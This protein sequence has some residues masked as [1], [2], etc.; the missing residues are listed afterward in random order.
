MSWLGGYK[1]KESKSVSE[2]IEESR[3]KKL[4][5]DREL[6][7]KKRAELQKRFE[8]SEKAK[9]E[10]EEACQ[11]LLDFDPD[12][13]QGPP[14]HNLSDDILYTTEVVKMVNFDEKNEDNGEEAMKSLG[15]I[16]VKWNPTDPAFFFQQLE[17]ELM[18][19]SVNK[20][21]TKRQAL[22]RNLPEDVSLEF[23]HLV[24]LQEDAAGD[25]A[26]KTLKTALLKAHGPRPG[27]AY[28]RAKNRVMLSKPS[29]L[30]K[31]LISDICN[32]NMAG[33][34]CAATV[35]GL[36]QDK[37]PMYLKTGL[38]NEIFSSTTSQEIMDKAD[39][40]WAANQP[41][42]PTVAAVSTTASV[43]TPVT[44]ETSSEIAAIGRGKNSF[45]GRNR[46]NRGFRGNGRGRS[47]PSG[48]DPRGKRHESNPPWN[49]CSAHWV[50][51]DKA[52]KCGAPTTC[53]MVN[54]V[55]PKS[56]N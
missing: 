26:Y 8:A 22:I 37:I 11:Q 41:N 40:L 14:D 27:D 56:Q 42:E 15:Q 34:C 51:Y 31:L 49:S 54:K 28:Q 7:A 12:I 44:A 48:P 53:P 45:R 17:T 30:L 39:N 52:W 47:I 24:I 3:R 9:K 4:E 23:K 13:F 35:W 46:G 1:P 25:M 16:K 29:V 2:S 33:C 55:T 38:A 36:F 32:K 43:S 18:I 5:A 19:F 6:R 50:H 10:A 20:Q 21:F